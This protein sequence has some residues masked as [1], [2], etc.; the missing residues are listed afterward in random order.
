LRYIP[1]SPEERAE[2]LDSIGL[3]SAEALFDSIP[4]NLLL[5]RP[6]NTPAALA[7]TELL[8]QFDQLAARNAGAG[9]VSFLGGGAY[10]HWQEYLY[11]STT[12]NSDPNHNGRRYVAIIPAPPSF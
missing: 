5:R 8:T 7:E 10:S 11:L 9:R 6:L 12:D 3:K 4:D 1:N 2:M